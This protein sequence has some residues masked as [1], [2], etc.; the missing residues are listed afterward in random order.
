MCNSYLYSWSRESFDCGYIYISYE[1]YFIEEEIYGINSTG[2]VDYDTIY[3]ND[4]YGGAFKVG[5]E[6]Q[7]KGGF[8]TVYNRDKNKKEVL[9]S[10]G[11]TIA[12][13][14]NLEIYVN[15]KDSSFATNKLIKVAETTEVLEPGFHRINIT[16]S[17]NWCTILPLS[18]FT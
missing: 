12:N 15:P 3:Q 1:D 18:T 7:L 13:Y 17:I 5:L 8:A 16:I 4:Y 6:T 14:A 9:N 10:V 2:S 11:V